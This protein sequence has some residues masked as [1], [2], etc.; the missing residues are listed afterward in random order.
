METMVNHIIEDEPM[1][2]GMTTIKDYDE[3]TYYHSVNVSILAIA[4]GHR[5]GISKKSLAQLGLSALLHDLGKIEVPKE[6]LNKSVEFT[7][8]DWKVIMKHPAWGALGVLKI[9]GVDEMS[10]SAFISAFEHHLNY[11]LSG[12]P[13]LRHKM[14][15]SF[16]SKIIAIADQYDAMTSSRVY[17]R[18]P[19]PPDKTLSIMVDRGG[20][21]LDPHLLKVFINM[22]GIY[23]LGSLVMLDTKELAIVYESN[24]NP[25]FGDR[26]R[27][28][29]LVDG[30]GERTK[31]IVDL[32]EKDEQGNFK[33]NV[34]KTLDPN[35]YKINL[36]DYLL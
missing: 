5:L 3:Y 24:T 17:S 6:I 4:L 1:L 14:T 7:E 34:V 18:V 32:M 10:M 36:A 15:P 33:R 35:Q 13:K 27:V 21:Q 12:Y 8:D 28:I 30:K 2:L 25:D 26:P 9:K 29:I 23:P 22:V 31:F 16:F 11:D 20:T 19:I